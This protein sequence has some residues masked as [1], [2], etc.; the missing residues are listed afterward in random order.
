M[1]PK[2]FFCYYREKTLWRKNVFLTD[3]CIFINNLADFFFI[4]FTFST[5]HEGKKFFPLTLLW[6]TFCYMNVFKIPTATLANDILSEKIWIQGVFCMKY[7]YIYIYIIYI[8]V[9]IIYNVMYYIYMLYITLYIFSFSPPPSY[10]FALIRLKI[11]YKN[12]KL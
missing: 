2:Q 7:I 9:W 3:F 5:H 8:N 1:T 6:P 11:T 12:I 4:N 10:R